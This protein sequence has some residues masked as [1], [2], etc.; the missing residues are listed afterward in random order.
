MALHRHGV[1]TFSR[2]LKYRKSRGLLCMSGACA[3]CMVNVDGIPNVRACITRAQ[4]GMA[5]RR[6][7]GWPSTEHDLV[8]FFL[9]IRELEAG[10]QYKAGITLWPVFMWAYTHLTGA[11]D[12]EID[13][14][15]KVDYSYRAVERDVVVVGGGP[16]GLGAA[17]ELA[18]TPLRFTLI[19][20]MPWL[21]GEQALFE[22]EKA[23]LPSEG[24][25][26]TIEEV[27]SAIGA[28]SKLLETTAV[29][30]Y[31]PNSLLA[32]GR[33]YKELVQLKA[34]RFVFATGGYEDIPL[35]ENSD[36]PG[37]YTYRASLIMSRGYEVKPGESGV[38][39]GDGARAD[40]VRQ[41]LEG[42]GMRI[43]QVSPK[44]VVRVT[45]S[46]RVTGVVVSAEGGHRTIR[47]DF[48]VAAD[49]INPRCELPYQAGAKVEYDEEAR[50]YR[51]THDGSM[52]STE[53][54]YTA[55]SM[56][57]STSYQESFRQ[58]RMAA[59]AVAHELTKDKDYETGM[60]ELAGRGPTP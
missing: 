49:G 25:A 29:G 3:Q 38:V 30:F 45:G 18:S 50:N 8:S 54:V 5:V 39:I 17:L 20:Q 47:A 9:G 41:R 59:L 19:E 33:N 16:A 23:G 40:L 55:G 48:A 24:G 46:R 22:G 28:D 37:F 57:G 35:I 4:D 58:G 60:L 13:K 1:R 31:K 42:A 7:R 27:S 34:Q 6:Q 15:P 52:R 44:D 53:V 36:V 14:V 26:R 32:V 11:G 2:S 21:G 51:P 12:L 10:F 43:V 56:C